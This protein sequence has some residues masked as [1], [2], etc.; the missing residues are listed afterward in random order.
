M[1]LD[2]LEWRECPRTDSIVILQQTD[3]LFDCPNKAFALSLLDR[4][5]RPMIWALER[6]GPHEEVGGP[7]R[8]RDHEVHVVPNHTPRTHPE[9]SHPSRT[10]RTV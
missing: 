10:R 8:A 1:S 5:G 3:A 7:R 4:L 2:F 9:R 6:K